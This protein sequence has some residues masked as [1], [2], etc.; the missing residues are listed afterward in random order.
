[1]RP[2]G[3]RPADAVSIRGSA[4]DDED[5]LVVLDHPVRDARL[6]VLSLLRV[7]VGVHPPQRQGAEGPR[8]PV[9]H[10]DRDVVVADECAEA[11]GDL[12]EDGVRIEGRE[13]RLGDLEEI[14]LAPELALEGSRLGAQ[15]LGRIGVRHRLGGETRVDHEQAQV[16]VAELVE[17]QLREDENAEDPVLEDHRGEEHRLR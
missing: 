17:P 3:G 9:E 15:L 10:L 12:V 16:V 1:M 4:I 8:G 6:A 13:D 7:L 2:P 14:A 11:V 5:R